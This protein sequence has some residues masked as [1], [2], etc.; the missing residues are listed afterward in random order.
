MMAR[1]LIPFIGFGLGVTAWSAEPLIGPTNGSLIIC[2]GGLKD[3]NILLRFIELAG[4]P[5]APIVLIPTA[6]EG[7]KFGTNWSYFEQ[8]RQLGATNLSILHTRDRA[9]ADTEEFIRPLQ[10]ARGVWMGGGRQWRLVD[11]YLH[12]RTQSALL[13]LLERGGVIGG[14]SAGSSIQASYLVRGAREGNTV[15]MAPGYEEGFGF[16]HD[17][18]IDQHLLTRNRKNDLLEVVRKHPALLG[19]GLDEDTAIVVRSNRFEV[20][21]KSKVAIYDAAQLSG[22]NQQPFYFL[23]SGDAFDLRTRKKESPAAPPAKGSPSK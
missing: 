4:G 15:M 6:K 3:T 8:L 2:G 7:E 22:T 9:V 5:S 16:L 1:C 23:Q 14:T 13:Q 17:T 21:G 18:A 12:T 11:S 19:I 20:I 10:T